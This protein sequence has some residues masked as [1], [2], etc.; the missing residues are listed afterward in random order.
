M[1]I[2]MILS[3]NSDNCDESINTLRLLKEVVCVI[4]YEG[5]LMESKEK[6]LQHERNLERYEK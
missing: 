1:S 4:Y 5:D 3:I 2:L 6:S